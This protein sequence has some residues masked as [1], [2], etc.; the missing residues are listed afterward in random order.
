MEQNVQVA[1]AVDGGSFA[2]GLGNGL[3]V[4]HHD[5]QV[6]DV[7]GLAQDDRPLGAHEAQLPDD[8][9]LRHD[10]GIKQH[11]D[12][13]EGHKDLLAHQIGP[14]QNVGGQHGQQHIDDGTH[15][16]DENGVED[17]RHHVLVAEDHLIVDQGE[18]LGEDLQAGHGAGLG[19][20]RQ[21]PGQDV[22]QGLHHGQGQQ[23]QED[24]QEPLHEAEAFFTDSIHITTLLLR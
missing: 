23:E 13:E 19:R 9:I 1:R 21:G 5:D 14:G 22:Q 15:G 20:I 18:A 7:A 3:K 6:V 11:H 17:G 2:Q 24:H 10:T 16:G 8:H 12:D 4:A